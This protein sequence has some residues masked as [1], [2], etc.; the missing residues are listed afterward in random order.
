MREGE[1]LGENGDM[2]SLEASRPKASCWRTIATRRHHTPPPIHLT[3]VCTPLLLVLDT[4]PVNEADMANHFAHLFYGM[5][6]PF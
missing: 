2:E 5:L 3:F 4:P 1:T 6:G